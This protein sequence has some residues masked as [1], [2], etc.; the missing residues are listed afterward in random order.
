MTNSIFYRVSPILFSI[1]GMALSHNLFFIILPL[2]MQSAGIESSQVGI[3]MGMFAA[4]SILAGMFGAKV[5]NRVGHIRA[6]ATMAATLSIVSILHTLL[7][8]F[9]ITSLLRVVPASASL[10][11]LSLLRAGLMSP[12]IA[13]TAVNCSV[14]TKYSLL[15]D[16]VQ[17]LLL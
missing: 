13:A 8:S 15:S 14:S 17:R 3:A 7:E 12:V 1:I 6:F 4:G 9:I 5:V 2:R 16:S 11:A 10:P